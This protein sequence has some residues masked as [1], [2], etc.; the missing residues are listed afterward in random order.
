M[1]IKQVKMSVWLKA[2]AHVGAALPLMILVINLFTNNLT[3]N[4]IQAAEQR[5]GRY[6]L[7]LL[8]LSLACT[9]IS[10][11]F[12]F[13]QVLP[14]R[15]ILGLYA[16]MYACLHLLTFFLDYGFDWELIIPGFL[17]KR[18]IIAG[19]AGFV[20]LLALAVTSWPW[21]MKKL[22][23]AWKKLH[24]LVYLAGLILVLHESWALK[25]DILALS[26]NIVQPLIFGCALIGLLFI[27]LPPLRKRLDGI[28][29]PARL[30]AIIS[31]YNKKY[32][33]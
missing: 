11:L 14:L 26:G 33:S 30:R 27:R 4:P 20:I 1:G 32:E 15:R 18:F 21:W 8:V 13:R 28:F 10:F 31:D 7:S 24:S 5:T 29:A 19:L 23:R 16:F 12:Y 6:A 3:A 2:A 22:G 17:E 25:G 9:P